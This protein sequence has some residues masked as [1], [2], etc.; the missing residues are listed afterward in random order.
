MTTLLTIALLIA[1]F[2][3]GMNLW[4]RN[5]TREGQ[6]RVPRLGNITPVNGGRIHY[7]EKGDPSKQTLVMIHGLT[8]QLQHFTYALVD[9][10][11]DDYHV[12]AVDRPGCG[13]STR[14]RA[15][16]GRLPEQARMIQEFLDSKDITDAILVGHSLGGAVSLA[17][18]LDHP[19]KIKALALLAPLT[20]V[21]ASTPRVFKPLEIRTEWL[22]SLIGNTIAVPLAAKTAPHTLDIVFAPDPAPAD[23]LDRAGGALGLRPSAFVTGSQD[24]VG[25]DD[26]ITAQV[27]RY[28]ELSVPGS[29][30]Y[31]T[32][33]A[34][35]S[36]KAHGD[37]MT[38][39][40]LTTEWIDGA[41]HMIL[42]TAPDTCAAFIRRVAETPHAKPETVTETV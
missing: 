13:Y 14:D 27:A 8:G 38:Q 19:E 4:T 22:R 10:L 3:I 23:F 30:L 21:L 39:F 35:L 37:P 33:D 20:Q 15:D 5:L 36:P 28:G 11:A 29:I 26:S 25:I 7:V 34:I 9:M 24:V 6:K 17:M 16:L 18:A 2:L 1:A 12:I 32:Q 41:G 42:I 40:G 31:G